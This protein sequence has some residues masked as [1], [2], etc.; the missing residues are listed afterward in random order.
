MTRDSWLLPLTVAASVLGYLLTVPAPTAWS[1]ADWLRALLVVLG[2]VA[3]QFGRSP[4]PGASKDLGRVDPSKF[5][6][7]LLVAAVSM[8]LLTGSTCHKST[9]RHDSVLNLS[10]LVTS[11]NAMQQGEKALYDAH[12]L[13]ALTAE[14]HQAFNRK[15]V[16]V[17]DAMDAAVVAVKAWRPGQPVSAQLGILLGRLNELLTETTEVIG[18]AIPVQVTAVWTAIAKI[19]IAIGGGTPA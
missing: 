3:A 12:T 15:M 13:P 1:Y 10:A 2:L 4:L 5:I 16:Q 14:R 19:L 11:L 8:S 17:W 18:V 7:P 6:A 9:P